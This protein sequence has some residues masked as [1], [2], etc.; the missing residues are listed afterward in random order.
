M[1]QDFYVPFSR[2]EALTLWSKMVAGWAKSLD[3]SGA[4]TVMDGIPNHNDVGGSYEGVTRM[5]WGLGSWLSYPERP[6]QLEW[7]GV[8]YDLEQ[9]TYRALVNGCD[10]NAP[11][12]WRHPPVHNRDQRTVESAQ[13]AFATWQ[14]RERIWSRMSEAERGNILGFL[15][16]VGQRPPRWYNNWALFWVLNHAA[17]KALNR[18]YDQSIIDAVIGDYLDGVYCGDGWYD[19]AEKYGSQYFDNYNTWVFAMHVMA[20][21]QMDGTSAPARRDELL[22]RV[23]AWMQHFPYF[24]AANG[25]TIEYGR[26]LAY[27]FCRLGAPLWSYKL[28]IWPHSTGMLKRLVGKHLRWY[29]DR[30]A[31]REDGTLRQTLTEA[32]SP[33]VRESYISTGAPYWAMQA[34][35][36]L[37]SLPDDDPFWNVEEEP[38][39]AEQGDFLKVFPQPGWVLAAQDGHVQQFNAGS[40]IPR[41]GSKYAKLVYST[42]HPFNV[43]LDASPKQGFNLLRVGLRST[44]VKKALRKIG[45]RLKKN[46]GQPGLDSCLCLREGE[47]RAQ[48]EQILAFAV[49]ETGWL[50]TRSLIELKGRRHTV[51]T[52]LIPLGDIHLR[53]HRITLDPSARYVIAEEGSA[54]LGYNGHDA[55]ALPRIRAENSW[56]FVELNDSAVGIKPLQGY[57]A[58]AQALSGSAN[59][60]YAHNLLAV[61]T[62]APLK[63]QHDLICLVYAGGAP[64]TEQI[65]KV[66]RAGW[67]ADGRFVAQVNGELISV[68]ALVKN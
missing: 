45:I 16:Q 47:W 41:Y 59:S 4:R 62:A 38:L 61:L 30:G 25:A 12:S 68:P 34:F 54:P 50:R 32:G 14:T 28:G 10:P 29:V 52:I 20:W 60:V 19:D 15:D 42:R 46:L 55:R 18:D 3:A 40:L 26:S 37:W 23:R 48:R 51:E 63:Q 27:K 13:V 21:S 64:A 17:R 43:G 53:A 39:P 66:E 35:S 22:D 31:L 56:L 5:L 24:F 8:A 49:G 1:T 11:G 44:R 6:A 2:A 33:E 67:E 65:P 36:G 57:S 58:A 7:C 9:L